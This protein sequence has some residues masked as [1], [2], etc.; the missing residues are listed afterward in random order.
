MTTSPA[1]LPDPG[2][3]SPVTYTARSPEDLLALVP[4]VLGFEPAESVVMFT[5]GSDRPFH[6]RVDLP[7]RGDPAACREVAESLVAAARNNSTPMVA[8]V[9][10]SADPAAAQPA[11]RALRRRCERA[12]IRIV[13]AMITDGRR[14]HPML[15]RDPRL[16][17]V[18]IPYDSDNHPFRARAVVTGTVVHPTRDHLVA[19]LDPDPGLQAGVERALEAGDLVGE[20]V[21]EAASTLREAGHRA[22]ALVS[23]HVADRTVA[24]DDEVARLVW[25]F[26]SARVRDAAWGLMRR[27][28]AQ[29]HLDFWSDVV[30]RTPQRLAAAPLAL[31]AYAAWLTGDGALAWA[32]VDRCRAV[33]PA[34]GLAGLVAFGLEHAVPPDLAEPRFDW[35]MGWEGVD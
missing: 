13:D 17:E 5:F 23:R 22:A 4:I 30:R 3:G 15:A 1:P 35:G 25:D 6:A 34:Y 10:Y 21:P 12:R 32:G 24:T 2:S 27:N 7:P 16:R 20:G 31:A 28:E 29:A 26:Q 11:W 9:L 33:D 18:G 14:Y 8:L 19:T